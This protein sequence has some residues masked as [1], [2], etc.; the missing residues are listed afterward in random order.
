MLRKSALTLAALPLFLTASPADAAQLKVYVS[1]A[2]AH[3][4]EVISEDFAKKNGHTI[5]LVVGTTGTI[6]E[7]V[8]K[9]EKADL[10]EI[11]NVGMDALEMEKLVVPGSRIDLARGLIGIAVPEGAASPNIATPEAVKQRLLSARSVAY[12]NPQGGGQAGAAITGMVA[13]MGITQQLAGKTVYGS[14]GADAVGKMAAGQADIA[15]SFVSEIIHVKG[16]KLVGELPKELQSPSLYS[17]AVGS[18]A[19]NPAAAR[20]L[21]QA[22]QSAESQ[23]I[24]RE[25]G[26]D[27]VTR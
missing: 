2:M 16:A 21:L 25:A 27:P 20:A 3:A 18:G 5:E 14:T 8:R 19:A 12:I 7:R 1:G 22:M 24:M 11:T 10:I 9:G 13:K 6:Q 26:L 17:G 4:L 23:K 15:I